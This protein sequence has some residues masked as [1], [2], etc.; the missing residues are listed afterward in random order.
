M[1]QIINIPIFFLAWFFIA[2]TGSGYSQVRDGIYEHGSKTEY[3]SGLD[4]FV[5]EKIDGDIQINKIGMLSPFRRY[6]WFRVGDVIEEV[7]NKRVSIDLLN[8]LHN[9]QIA[10]I[11]YRRR[12]VVE[13]KQI[14]LKLSVYGYPPHIYY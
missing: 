12:L 4:L 9:N 13:K 2:I 8:N 1:K 6:S 14:D 11:K 10:W 7:N 3:I 5:V